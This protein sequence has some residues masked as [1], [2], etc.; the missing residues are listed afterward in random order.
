V[1][2][3]AKRY[4]YRKDKSGNVRALLV[5]ERIPYKAGETI[6]SLEQ[7]VARDLYDMEC[8]QDPGLKRLEAEF[9]TTMMRK[10]WIENVERD[11]RI[12]AARQEAF[13][14]ARGG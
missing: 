7:R 8:R 13:A 10:V 4:V 2:A 1:G 9:G 12:D 3:G 14:R 11:N 6:A 5:S